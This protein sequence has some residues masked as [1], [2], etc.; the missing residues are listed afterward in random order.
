MKQKKVLEVWCSEKPHSMN[1]SGVVCHWNRG[2][3]KK[4]N[5]S[6]IDYVE[7][8]ADHL[9]L[10][11][12]AFIYE[13]GESKIKNERLVELF[14][15]SNGFNLWWMS[16][17]AEKNFINSSR[18]SD[19]IKL[20]ALEEILHIE[21][22]NTVIFSGDD[23]DLLE[24]IKILCL[25]MK[26][27]FSFSS[28]ELHKKN[29]IWSALRKKRPEFLSATLW[30][31]R[32]ICKHWKV[33][34]KKNPCWSTGKDSITMVSNFFILNEKKYL[35][36]EFESK[37]WGALPE[38]VRSY[39]MKVN[40]LHHFRVGDVVK[41]SQS[42][43][44]FIGKLNEN[45]DQQ[46]GHA[47]FDGYLSLSVIFRVYFNYLQLIFKS[48]LIMS[49]KNIFR[50]CN[51]ANNF[52]PILKKDWRSSI[53]GAVVLKNILFIELVELALKNAPMQKFGVYLLE[54]HSWERAF[55]HSWR[56]H[57]HGVLI[58]VQHATVLFWD[59]VYFDDVRTALQKDIY[60]QARPDYVAVNGP[61]AMSEYINGGYPKLNLVEVEALRYLDLVNVK[62]KLMQY[63]KNIT[64]CDFVGDKKNSV[65]ILGDYNRDVTISMLHSIVSAIKGNSLMQF[66]FKPHPACIINMDD[67]FIPGLTKTD[68][69]LSEILGQF[70]CAI[71]SGSSSASIDAYTVG[72]HLIV[73]LDQYRLNLSPVR[74][75]SDVMFVVNSNEIRAAFTKLFFP[76]KRSA[77]RKYFW[78]DNSVPRWHRFLD[79][80]NK[81]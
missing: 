29:S 65:I 67:F 16:S 49:V 21:K 14:Q 31:I 39:G 55:I 20:F 48:A 75:F 73:Y 66:T 64:D 42:A 76:L 9:R 33:R 46:G 59:L 28:A 41:D 43:F 2:C 80:L 77:S 7:L 32:Y 11:Y 3:S 5:Y 54:N 24:S 25:N 62:S 40:W 18:I 44:D 12:L 38:M 51:S 19:A 27:I 1:G 74:G 78:L 71:T 23:I 68:K 22:P 15:T 63:H 81:A 26:I 58:G 4:G 45:S 10:K 60:S 13:L 17:L 79:H 35:N 52:W 6:I 34:S 50:P 53:K 8:N 57:G 30:F 61:A 47:F 69:P 36:G 37:Q 56:R 70:D 72:L